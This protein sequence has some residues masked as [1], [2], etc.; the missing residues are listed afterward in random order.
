M[1]KS[2]R[3]ALMVLL[4]SLAGC[5]LT[6][7]DPLLRAPIPQQW[8]R[9]PSNIESADVPDWQTFFVAPSLRGLIETTLRN[10]RD[11]RV[12]AA[13]IEAAR[14]QLGLARAALLPTL[15]GS[16]SFTRQKGSTTSGATQG[17]TS[18]ISDQYQADLGVSAYELD[19]FGRLRS[20]RDAALQNYVAQE[21]TRRATQISL[22]AEVANAYFSLAADN[23]RLRL[24]EQTLANQQDVYAITQARYQQEV[25]TEQDRVQAETSVRSAQVDVAQY[26]RLAEQ[27]RLALELLAGTVL[28]LPLTQQASLAFTTPALGETPAGLPSQLLNRRPDILAA[29]AQLEAANAN[30][31][32]ARAAFFPTLSLTASGG[33]ASSELGHLFSAGTAIW[34]FAPSV[35][36]PI[37]DGGTRRANLQAAQATREARVAAYEKAIQTAFKEVAQ[38]LAA[39]ADYQVEHEAQTLN[40]KANQRYFQ[41]ANARYDQGADTYLNVLVAQRS[42]YQSQQA[43]LTLQQ[44]LLVNQMNLFKA[45]GGGWQEVNGSPLAASGQP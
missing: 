33:V 38:A 44:A 30:I 26:R 12:A 9:S 21:Q 19:V 8:P 10:N 20:L 24:A 2:N 15:N 34:T 6:P 16:G 1:S 32:A 40:V 13:N 27:D 5:S 42:L 43:L 28:P 37:F 31:G 39:K 4:A 17:N 22:V 36:L 45:L 14:A 18:S 3:T 25:A 23:D 7:H 29:Q 41:L 35:T 11:L